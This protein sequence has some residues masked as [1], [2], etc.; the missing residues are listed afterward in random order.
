MAQVCIPKEITELLK[1]NVPSKVLRQIS[2]ADT[3][4]RT[5]VIAE[6]VDEFSKNNLFR[7]EGDKLLM[8]KGIE[9]KI[10]EVQKERLIKAAE[11]KRKVKTEG[12]A[13]P[14]TFKDKIDQ[15]SSI[16]DF[17]DELIQEGVE[18]KLGARLT[19][20]EIQKLIVASEEISKYL[21]A[22]G[23]PNQKAWKTKDDNGNTI[24]REITDEYGNAYKNYHQTIDSINPSNF[25]EK[26]VAALTA[27]LLLNIKSTLINPI[28][29]TP[30][31]AAFTLE[32][33]SRYGNADMI[34]KAGDL[35]VKD[36]VF[37]GKFK[38]DA[39]RGF[40][41]D[42]GVKT[43]GETMTRFNL[44]GNLVEKAIALQNKIVFDWALGVPD[45]A[46]GS[47]G[48][49]M[50]AFGLAK[51]EV[52]ADFKNKGIKV[53]VGNK[54]YN[55]AFNSLI[56]DSLLPEP[57]TSLGTEIKRMSIESAD[58]ITYREQSEIAKF[59]SEIRS[60]LDEFGKN[61][62]VKSNI[63]ED[64]ASLF[65]L[66]KLNIPFIMTTSNVIT[67]GAQYSGLN[68]PIKSLAT[69]LFKQEPGLKLADSIR[70]V[71]LEN[72]NTLLKD[73]G[74]IDWRKPAIGIPLA[75][76]AAS[77]IQP[78]DYIG[79]YPT[80]PD[81]QRLI[82]LGRAS[83]NSVRVNIKGQE[84]WVSLDILGPFAAPFI[85]IL[86]AKKQKDVPVSQLLLTYIFGAAGQLA[87]LPILEG[88]ENIVKFV[89]KGIKN[90]VANIS[91]AENQQE[92]AI[93]TYTS[94]ANS[95]VNF[96][97]ARFLPSIV[98]DVG[99]AFDTENVKR[100]TKTGKYTY[101]NVSF[102]PFVGKIPGLREGLP[103]KRDVFGEEIKT[104]GLW[105]IFFGARVK[106]ASDDKIV[107]ELQNMANE[108]VAKTPT[109]Y[110]GRYA[111]KYYNIPDDKLNEEK[112]QYGKLLYEAYNKT[113]ES[114]KWDSL[115]L[116]DKKDALSK[117]E[118]KVKDKYKNELKKRYG[119][120]KTEE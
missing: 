10:I 84:K 21:D 49:Y 114:S 91:T 52:L 104:E 5:Q 23:N 80:D 93:E 112:A 79:N 16:D 6:M 73:L 44:D 51:K 46:F 98:G 89:E 14:D 53:E 45:Q 47:Y 15:I 27:N 110:I 78:E 19:G 43:L 63:P 38:Y 76:I 116:D 72:Y 41:I 1:K 69:V 95:L 83:E 42:A 55:E 58:K 48:Y 102:D 39:A 106:T 70:G 50:T 2:L 26:G 108:G 25:G 22:D 74:Q 107:L 100:D 36:A 117:A 30:I 56:N 67:T 8:Q 77:Y 119:Q 65:K 115:N 32:S 37:F 33:I 92:I 75:F 61:M 96:M 88:G 59:S 17:T 66:G 86:E 60:S 7:D 113:I 81:E 90:Y 87:E 57:K 31:T 85:G 97:S 54:E 20:D 109:D 12:R 103:E 105:Q 99:E 120:V 35:A 94:L 18:I 118:T 29:Q 34:A 24:I 71:R 111:Q 82:E 11:Y 64:L 62:L 9:E 40:D 13:E 28:A 3:E 101:G 4:K 68:I